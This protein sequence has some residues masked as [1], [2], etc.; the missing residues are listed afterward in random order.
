MGGYNA[1][2][3]PYARLMADGKLIEAKLPKEE[4]TSHGTKYSC[5]DFVRPNNTQSPGAV[6]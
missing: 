1:D 5:F 3:R 2:N 4:W 6:S